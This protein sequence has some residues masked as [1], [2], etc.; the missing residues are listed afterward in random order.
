MTNRVRITSQYFTAHFPVEASVRNKAFNLHAWSSRNPSLL[1]QTSQ[2][3]IPQKPD[4][5]LRYEHF[6]T[7]KAALKTGGWGHQEFR[8]LSPAKGEEDRTAH[9]QKGKYRGFGNHRGRYHKVINP[10]GPA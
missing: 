4:F 6:L 10:V 7:K 5:H 2:T 1:I 3:F 8:S 9:C